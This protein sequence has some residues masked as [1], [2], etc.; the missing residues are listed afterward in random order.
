MEIQERCNESELTLTIND[1]NGRLTQIDVQAG[2]RAV[3]VVIGAPGQAPDATYV[4]PANSGET[5]DL[6]GAEQVQ[7]F[8]NQGLNH[9]G[10]QKD[11]RSF[12]H[13]VAW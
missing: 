8:L 12:E 11:W 4:T 10:Q 13:S 9:A 7:T 1:T 2:A 6:M 5:F 3:T